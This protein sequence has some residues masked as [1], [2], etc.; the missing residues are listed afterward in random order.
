VNRIGVRD[1]IVDFAFPLGLAERLRDD[2]ITLSVEEE[3]IAA[4]RRHKS[5]AELAGIR[6][7]QVAA[8]AAME[9][10]ATMLRAAGAASG[11]LQ[12]DGGPLRAED[13]RDAMRE[14]AWRHG[15]LLSSDAIVASVW[16]GFGHEPGSGP[17]PEGLPIQIDLWPQDEASSCWA[18]MAR[19]FVVG[20]ARSDEIAR[21]E[22]LVRDALEAVRAEVRPGVTGEALHGLCCDIFEAAGYRT[23]RTGPGED[24]AEGFQFSLGHGVGLRVHEDPG[25]GQ[26]G[27][28]PLIAGDVLAIE[29]GLW[30]REVGGVRFE[31]LLLVTETGCETLT[32]FAY[33]LAP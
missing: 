20:E 6:R 24:R 1:A 18:D 2:G 22:R 19:T 23:Q 11:T 3:T 4:R 12:L 14:A 32:S 9:A 30:H 13:V 8:H 10:A 7:A 16:Q 31:D 17:L 26:S 5:D 21:Q 33:D 28:A 29:P 15:A 27:R 25:L